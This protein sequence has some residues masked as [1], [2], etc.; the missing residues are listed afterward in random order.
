[1]N[2]NLL[3]LFTIL[4]LLPPV[5]AGQSAP[6]KLRLPGDVQPVRY[7]LNLTILPGQEDFSGIVDVDLHITKE[8]NV[9]W[10][11][12]A[13]LA[14]QSAKVSTIGTAREGKILPGDSDFLGIQVGEPV[15]PGAARLELGYQGKLNSKS[16]EGLFR[17]RVGDDWYAF[18]QFEAIS[19]R[20]AFPC[21][22]EPSYKVPWQVTLQVK[23]EDMALTNTPASGETDVGGG[24][25]AVKFAETK[26][27][28]SY[29]VAFA[30]GPFDAVDAGKAGRKKTPIRI[31]TPR[32]K[33]GDAKYAVESTGRI[34][35]LLEEYFGIAYPYE[36]LDQ[37][38]VPLFFGAME[39]PGLVTYGDTLILARPEQDSIQRQRRYASIAAHELAHQWFG[40]LVTMKWWDDIWLNEAFASWMGQKITDRFR[41]DWNTK[42][43]NMTSKSRAMG[44]DSLVSARR[45]RQP[46]ET[47]DDIANA[48]DGITY[49]KG[50]AVIEM[51]ERWVGEEKFRKGVHR[52]LKKF[53]FSSA[54]ADDFLTSIEAAGGE[55]VKSAFSTFLDQPGVPLLT[56]ELRC[57]GGKPGLE[58]SQKRSLPLGSSGS[59]Q[60]TWQIPICVTYDSGGPRER[61]CTLMRGDRFTWM[62]KQGQSCPTWLLSNDGEIG[63]FRTLYRGD[64][65]RRLLA[66]RGKKLSEAER[67]GLIQEVRDLTESG[68]LPI[69]E[70]LRLV[71]EFIDDPSRF[72]ISNLKWIADTANV[73]SPVELRPNFARFVEKVFGPKARELGWKPAPGESEDARLMRLTVTPFVAQEGN[74]HALRQ[75]ARELALRWLDD[76]NVV[77]PELV[78]AVLNTAAATGDRGLHDNFLAAAKKAKEPREVE[79]LLGALGSFH[80]PG[81]VKENLGLLLKDDFDMRRSLGL[82]FGP[83][84]YWKTREVPFQWVKENYNALRSRLPRAADTDFAAFLPFAGSGFCDAH[85]AAEVESFF[86]DKM[87]SATG[88]PRNLAQAV[89][90]IR[91]CDAARKAHQA[92]IADFLKGY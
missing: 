18:T 53:S 79:W 7:R 90:G 85:G 16:S 91:L 9:I 88:G 3:R 41:P 39:N 28:S 86:K 89:E 22:D 74:D 80:D 11:N 57:D 67:V 30:V 24:M 69:H 75:E 10:I 2:R 83:L 77:P 36:K 70:A 61:E 76:R 12:A 46:I 40:D 8:T 31:I 58:L 81:I 50:A 32:G 56:V 82:L 54:T 49:Q 73:H 66:D 13:D 42:V 23:K 43:A 72:V 35:T 29:L 63:Y 55:S 60:Q 62:L 4:F 68:D 14:V 51:F 45:I 21:F 47:K 5:A 19:A 71:P 48:F 34:L 78:G 33:A 65:L 27:L 84:G 52:Y 6:P 64:L 17:N 1:V 87:A 15:K 26:P 44:Q 59:A 38:A 37:V 92:G 20:R 25:K